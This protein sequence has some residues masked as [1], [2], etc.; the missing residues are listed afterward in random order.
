MA[1]VKHLFS[2][3]DGKGCAALAVAMSASLVVGTLKASLAVFLSQIF[4]IIADFGKS[5]ITGETALS[6]VSSWCIVLALVGGGAWIANFVLLLSWIAHGERQSRNS[7][8]KSFERLL[9]KD[10]AWFD[11]LPE[12]SHSFLSGLYSQ[13]RE[14]Q[15]A[16]SVALGNLTVDIVASVASLCVAFYF[17]WRLT[18]VL[19][20]TIPIAVLVLGL[21]SRQI[22]PAIRAHH[23]TLTAAS[24]Y[25][26]STLSS[27]DVVKVFNGLNHEVWH[28]SA[29]IN[30][31]KDMYLRQ[32]RASTCQMGFVKCWLELLFVLGL[33]Y[34]TV[35]VHGG[36]A[37]VSNVVASFYATL[38]ALQA[39]ESCIPMYL[40]LVKGMLAGDS[41]HS[42]PGEGGS[43]F[44]SPGRT[45]GGDKCPYIELQDVTFA[46]PSNPSNLVLRNV[47]LSFGRR[48][49]TFIVGRSGSGKT[50]LGNL[51]AKLYKPLSG[52]VLLDGYDLKGWQSESVRRHITLVQ[53]STSLFDQKLRTNIEWAT[54]RQSDRPKVEPH[55]LSEACKTAS[56]QPLI[57]KLPLG[58]ETRIGA[59]GHSLSGGETQRVA[60][61]RARVRDPL[62]LI[63]DEVTSN[64]DPPT[65]NQIMEDIRHWRHDKATIIITHDLSLINDDDYVF[66]LDDGRVVQEGTRKDAEQEEG[67]F[68]HLLNT[69]D[70]HRSCDQDDESQT[71]EA[72]QISAS[73]QALMNANNNNNTLDNGLSERHLPLWVIY[74]TVWPHL[75]LKYRLILVVGIMCALLIAASVPAFSVIFAHLLVVL[76]TPKQRDSDQVRWTLLLFM[77]AVVGGLVTFL[78]YHLCDCAAQAWIDS[79]RNK[80]M[81][82]ILVQPRA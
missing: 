59:S 67:P 63:L 81:S 9:S 22:E 3:T 78:A 21:L 8:I 12:G 56:L 31:S 25:V 69:V 79:L 74:R 37:S 38:G 13:I 80:A 27:I 72:R 30:R 44:K 58:L 2:F 14:L 34:G 65:K 76:Y 55:E 64:L 75:R 82:R 10:V 71:G 36:A 46:Y 17:C 24:S 39:I 68:T 23:S 18:L 61:A 15:A 19:F 4:P 16:S 20:S 53:Q 48:P 62:T 51:L 1:S 41:L 54:N 7:R 77:V 29:V 43:G 28:Y 33:F 57:F 52:S 5:I 26:S 47:S 6:R 60:V 49:V 40:V 50:T 70:D 66:V 73:S 11:G 45:L 32:S 42:F 35:L